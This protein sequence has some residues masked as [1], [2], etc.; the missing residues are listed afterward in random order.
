M[1]LDDYDPGDDIRDLGRGGGGGGFSFGGGGG[2]GIGGL[3]IGLLPMLLGRKLGCGTIAI[4]GIVVVGFLMFSGG[5]LQLSGGGTGGVPGG[6]GT[7]GSGGGGGGKESAGMVISA[8]S[9]HRVQL[10]GGR[11][12]LLTTAK[13]E[14]SL[15]SQRGLPPRPPT[16]FRRFKINPEFC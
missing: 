1:R 9:C 16:R 12:K 8:E 10:F 6:G 3:L 4:L 15:P 13:R 7:G 11:Q 14:G 5:G 2:G